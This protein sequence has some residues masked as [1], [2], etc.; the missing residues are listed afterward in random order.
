MSLSE[1]MPLDRPLAGMQCQIQPHTGIMSCLKKG[2]SEALA[3]GCRT[4]T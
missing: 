4:P 3:G 2:L 1:R